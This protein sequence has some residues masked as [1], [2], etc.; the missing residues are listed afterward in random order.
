MSDKCGSWLT[1]IWPWGGGVGD[2]GSVIRGNHWRQ[3]VRSRKMRLFKRRSSDPI[4]P[5]LTGLRFGEVRMGAR[6]SIVAKYG[7]SA[8]LLTKLTH[9]KKMFAMSTRCALKLMSPNS[10]GETSQEYLWNHDSQPLWNEKMRHE[11]L[12]RNR[13]G[14][15]A[16]LVGPGSISCV[17]SLMQDQSFGI[18]LSY[19]DDTSLFLVSVTNAFSLYQR[20]FIL[21]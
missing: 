6:S 10:G 3:I 16:S 11:K 5:Q 13:H 2:D 9:W 1:V 21:E 4:D 14:L 7:S 19:G 15:R 12:I 20:W 18:S 8:L 17:L